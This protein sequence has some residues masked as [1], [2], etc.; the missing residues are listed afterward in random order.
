M[1]SRSRITGGSRIPRSR[2]RQ[3]SWGTKI[4]I[5]QIFRKLYEIENILGRG[6][7]PKSATEDCPLVGECIKTFP[8]QTWYN[9]AL[10]HLSDGKFKKALTQFKDSLEVYKQLTEGSEESEFGVKVFESI[11][12][13]LFCGSACLYKTLYFQIQLY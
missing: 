12:R 11:G 10:P 6:A 5:C 13:S 3:P 8:F 9:F 1:F 7:P 4:Q 2:G